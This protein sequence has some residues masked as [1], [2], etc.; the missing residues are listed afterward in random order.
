MR[1]HCMSPT[2]FQ[3]IIFSSK[4]CSMYRLISLD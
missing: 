1:L 4:N 3:L 2:N